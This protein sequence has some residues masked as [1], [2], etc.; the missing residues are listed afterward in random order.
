MRFQKWLQSQR[1]SFQILSKAERKFL[2]SYFI[3]GLAAP[4]AF[5]YMNTYLWRVNEDP[6]LL[7]LYNAGFFLALWF[8]F[9][10]NTF[11][12]RYTRTSV[13]YTIGSVMQGVVPFL[14][15]LLGGTVITYV[16]PLGLVLGLAGGLYWANRNYLVSKVTAG[17]HRFYFLS[18]ES[19]ADTVAGIIAPIT[20]G[21]IIVFGEVHGFY[22]VDG[23]YRFVTVLSILMLVGAGLVVQSASIP[24]D[25]DPK[26][27]LLRKPGKAWNRLRLLEVAHGFIH[28]I[29]SVLPVIITLQFLGAEGTVGTIQTITALVATII[30]ALL[31]RHLKHKH[32]LFIL[33]FWLGGTLIGS[34]LFATLFSAAGAVAYFAFNALTGTFRWASLSTILYEV[35]DQV[36]AHSKVHRVLYIMD[37]EVFLNI[38][39]LLGLLLIFALTT[40]SSSVGIRFGLLFIV[41]GQFAL[42]IIARP[43]LSSIKTGTLFPSA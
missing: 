8:G 34:A 11:L 6:T 42:I 31:G 3:F 19:V 28:G 30:L 27:F 39:R 10:L 4:I 23:A 22:T 41:G 13:L 1:Q 35:I 32:H 2:I 43:L 15:V 21:W 20:I 18:L 37:R 14:I 9:Q 5:T 36:T 24:K 26:T 33:L 25:P 12:L 7:I 40:F 29:E 38:G 16:F 17:T